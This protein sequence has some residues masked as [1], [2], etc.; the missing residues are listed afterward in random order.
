MKRIVLLLLVASVLAAAPAD[1][2]KPEK[3]GNGN[4]HKGHSERG[5]PGVSVDV[6]VDV[7]LFAPPQR[8]VVRGWIVSERGRGHCPPGLAKKNNG[9]LPPGQAK[10]RYAVGHPLPHGIVLE[11]LPPALEVRIGL[12]PVGYRYGVI[13]GDVVKLALGTMLVVDAIDGLVD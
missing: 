4:G 6:D 2:K 1:A 3:N 9:C 13:D 8:E 7:N 5:A 10:K 12:P 11:P